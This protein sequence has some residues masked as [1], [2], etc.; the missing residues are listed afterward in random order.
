M[1]NKYISNASQKFNYKHPG[2]ALVETAI[3]VSI[4]SLLFMAA[5][6]AG[7]A[8]RSFQTLTN[9]TA[10]ASSYLS[11]NPLAGTFPAVSADD[12][13]VIAR[14]RLKEEQAGSRVGTS[15]IVDAAIEIYE[16]DSG[17]IN[18][19]AGGAYGLVEPFSNSVN[20]DCVD[21]EN[22]DSSGNPCFIVIKSSLVYQPFMLTPFFGN[23]LTIR[24]TSVKPI[25]GHPDELD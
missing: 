9:A 1:T 6:D 21:R 12:A 13:D 3:A 25:V 7:L 14:Q 16:A 5:V 4:L 8:Y 20:A 24:V 2:Q 10:E 15:T 17:Q 22:F 23:E 19:A 11:Q 18:T